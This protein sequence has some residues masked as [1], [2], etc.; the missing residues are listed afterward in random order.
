MQR[1]DI[2]VGEVYAVGR[3]RRDSRYRSSGG[4]RV[5]ILDVD[6]DFGP[7]R[8]WE[9]TA[10]PQRG[11]LGVHVDDDGQPVNVDMWGRSDGKPPCEFRVEPRE[12]WHLW[13]EE[14]AIRKAEQVAKA[15]REK[16]DA[17]QYARL[18]ALQTAALELLPEGQE[19]EW[20]AKQY[21]HR[22]MGG[23]PVMEMYVDIKRLLAMLRAAY[24][25]GMDEGVW[26]G[27]HADGAS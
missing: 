4:R 9:R 17:E 10:K 16:A 20:L 7:Q 23:M 18:R 19:R 11:I 25:K 26:V 27:E 8:P 5:K 2:K 15:A 6:H 12:V 13:S 14:V 22:P 1:K 3:G 21:P 24:D